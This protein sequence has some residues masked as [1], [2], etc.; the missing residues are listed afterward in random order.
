MAGKRFAADQII[1]KLREAELGLAPG[2]ATPARGQPR[3]RALRMQSPIESFQK[4][5]PFSR[6]FVQII[7]KERLCCATR[8]T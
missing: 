6:P 4:S 8:P 5:G 3:M 7:D 2:K 1:M